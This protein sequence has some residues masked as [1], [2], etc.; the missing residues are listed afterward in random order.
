MSNATR[1]LYQIRDG[2]LRGSILH[3]EDTFPAAAAWLEGQRAV[4][5]ATHSTL[6]PVL[7][8]VVETVIVDHPD[9]RGT[10]E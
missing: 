4:V 2:G 9:I 6:R 1:T 8:K 7:V 5:L 3:E 10:M